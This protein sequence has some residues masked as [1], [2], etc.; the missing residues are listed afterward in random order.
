[1]NISVVYAT[2]TGHSRKIAERLAES[3][4]V[5]AVNAKD[6]PALQNIDLLF[7][8][9]GIYGGQSSPDLT[10][11]ADKSVGTNVKNVFIITTSMSQKTNQESLK[12]TLIDKGVNV[13]D[14][15][16]CKGSFLFFLGFSHP[17]KE[18]IE[19]IVEKAKAIAG[20]VR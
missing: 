1:M 6:S 2:M 5:T 17:N 13:I 19:Q 18:D 11:F 9:G 10:A 4:G 20:A 12:N 16:T 3:F 8:V 14:E 15:I 7:I